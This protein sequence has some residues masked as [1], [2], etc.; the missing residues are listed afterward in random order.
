MKRGLIIC[1]SCILLV[2]ALTGC[3]TPSESAEKQP[4]PMT[5]EEAMAD[6]TKMVAGELPKDLR[7]SIYYIYP[8]LDTRCP[9]TKEDL[10]T[11]HDVKVIVVESEELKGHLDLL[12]KLGPSVLEPVE[13]PS[14]INARLYYVFE[15]GDSEVILDVVTGAERND[16]IFVN[17]IEVETNPVF[18]ELILPFLTEEDCEILD[19]EKHFQ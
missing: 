18:Y 10:K 19:I 12:R 15:V 2:T 1:L 14:Y 11:F 4:E 13:E 17:G 7:L 8:K 3:Q 9:V 5:L 16:T 6:Y